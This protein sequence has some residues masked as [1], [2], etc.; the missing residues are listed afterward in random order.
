MATKE[1]ILDERDSD[2]HLLDDKISEAITIKNGLAID[3]PRRL[4]LTTTINELMD[5]RTDLHIQALRANLRSAQLAAALAKITTAS[6]NLKTEAAKMK[7][8]TSFINNVN[9]VIGAATK[10]TNIVKN[11]G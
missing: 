9:A 5:A 4:N 3:D 7:D 6:Q 2:V 10:V 11:G 8:V 1:E